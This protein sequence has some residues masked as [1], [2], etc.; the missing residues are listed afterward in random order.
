M[1]FPSPDWLSQVPRDLLVTVLENTIPKNEKL[2]L[3][4]K[5]TP[6][7]VNVLCTANLYN[8]FSEMIYELVY[9]RLYF[10]R[11]WKEDEF[12]NNIRSTPQATQEG[13]PIMYRQWFQETFA[14]YEKERAVTIKYLQTKVYTPPAGGQGTPERSGG[15]RPSGSK[16]PGAKKR[17][18]K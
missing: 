9:S 6:S 7:L 18:K 8:E 12:P 13:G 2:R 5:E 15:Q 4:D 16:K 14:A 10:P 17:P 1:S 11:R 3:W